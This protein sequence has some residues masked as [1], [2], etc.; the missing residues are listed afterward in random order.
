MATTFFSQTNPKTF[1][2]DGSYAKLLRDRGYHY[3]DEAEISPD[4]TPEYERVLKNF[5]VE[6]IHTDDEIRCCDTPLSQS[7]LLAR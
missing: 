5:Y 7:F 2:K 4:L 3:Q 6:H 1:V